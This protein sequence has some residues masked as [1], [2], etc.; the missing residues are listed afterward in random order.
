MAG[1]GWTPPRCERGDRGMVTAELALGTVAALVLM[2]L[3]GGCLGLVGVQLANGAIAAEVAE[4]VARGDEEA[5]ERAQR[6]GG[7]DVE[8]EV[9]RSAGGVVVRASRE[10]APVGP[11]G[12]RLTITGSARASWQPGEDGS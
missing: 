7:D 2:V 1:T 10:V 8:V 5:A 12:P 3:L 4:Q 11:L 6:R 9:Q